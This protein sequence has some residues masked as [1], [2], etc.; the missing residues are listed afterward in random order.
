MLKFIFL[1]FLS[2]HIIID[3]FKEKPNLI[4]DVCKSIRKKPN[5]NSEEN[6]IE[7][8]NQYLKHFDKVLKTHININN[9]K[10]YN[11]NVKTLKIEKI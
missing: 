1:Q 10:L 5:L 9:L 4:K 7:C 3:F 6:K 8:D 2:A 11:N